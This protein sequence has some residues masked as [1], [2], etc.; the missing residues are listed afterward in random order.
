MT[1]ATRAL[2]RDVHFYDS[3]DPSVVLGGLVL[4]TGV[5]NKNFHSMLEVLI[6]P[7]NNGCI[8]LDDDQPFFTLK[9]SAGN[10]L[11]RD[12]L[13]LKPGDYHIDGRGRLL[14]GHL[15]IAKN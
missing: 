2:M 5:T 7:E 6:I 1:L 4:N 3:K 9:D 12:D 13:P 10:I 8:T 11:Q 14:H 15:S